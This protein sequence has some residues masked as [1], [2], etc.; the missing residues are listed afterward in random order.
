MG[1]AITTGFAQHNYDLKT[2][3]LPKQLAWVEGLG[4][5]PQPSHIESLL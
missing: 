5:P 3:C 1:F 4:L 2:V